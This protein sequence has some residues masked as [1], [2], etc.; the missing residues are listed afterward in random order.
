MGNVHFSGSFRQ[1][2]IIFLIIV[3]TVLALF[4]WEGH[5]G[6]SISDEGFLW[7]GAQRVMQGEVP[8][9]DFNAYV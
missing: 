5:Q 4:F 2:I 3:T 6:F 8:C 9:R 1:I 7:Y